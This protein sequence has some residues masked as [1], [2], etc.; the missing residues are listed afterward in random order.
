MGKVTEKEHKAFL[1][2]MNEYIACTS[3]PKVVL[4][5]SF[6]IDGNMKGETSGLAS[7]ILSFMYR[8]LCDIYNDMKSLSQTDNVKGPLWIIKMWLYQYLPEFGLELINP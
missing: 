2:W 3:S 4:E 6:Q 7:S 5:Y 1:S 8:P